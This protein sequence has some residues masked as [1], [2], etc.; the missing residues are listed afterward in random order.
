MMRPTTAHQ[1]MKAEQKT[2]DRKE[3]P[4]HQLPITTNQPPISTSSRL[5]EERKTTRR[6]H[7]QKRQLLCL[8]NKRIETTINETTMKNHCAV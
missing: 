1:E 2:E 3:K 7:N 8:A 4:N 5:G 6:N